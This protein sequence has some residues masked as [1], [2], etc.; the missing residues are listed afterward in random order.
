[1]HSRRACCNNCISSTTGFGDT[2]TLDTERISG[3]SRTWDIPVADMALSK[4]HYSSEWETD[5]SGV[6]GF[7]PTTMVPNL[8]SRDRMGAIKALVN[9]LHGSGYV[10]DSLRF[11]Q[12]VLDREDLESTAVGNGIAFPHARC[13]SAAHLGMALGISNHGVDF[14]SDL[15]PEPVRLICL[16]AVPAEG[17]IRY[18]PL[19]GYLCRLFHE[20][21]TGTFLESRTAEQMNRLLLRQMRLHGALPEACREHVPAT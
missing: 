12:S 14:H 9:R 7:H 18:L 4:F 3:L 19:L 15:Y 21:I 8:E 13:G 17:D 11:L 20:D 5:L 10:T 1:M 6:V 16:V 2:G